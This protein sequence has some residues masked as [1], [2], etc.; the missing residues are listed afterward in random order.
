MMYVN[1][2]M[3]ESISMEIGLDDD[4]KRFFRRWKNEHCNVTRYEFTERHFRLI[5]SNTT[6]CDNRKADYPKLTSELRTQHDRLSELWKSIE[7]DWSVPTLLKWFEYSFEP[8]WE[9]IAYH[10]AF[11][12]VCDEPEMEQ[13][14]RNRLSGK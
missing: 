11:L 4:A 3:E 1:K 12:T 8:Y 7:D 5:Y 2:D 14:L 13:R 9:F 6:V 10:A